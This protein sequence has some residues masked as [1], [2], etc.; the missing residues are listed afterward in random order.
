LSLYG[1]TNQILS[2]SSS[3]KVLT[4]T[5]KKLIDAKQYQEALNVFDQQSEM[6]TDFHFNMALKAC[7][8]LHNYQYGKKIHQQ[9]S[10]NSLNN[11]FIQSSLINF[12]SESFIFQLENC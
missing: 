5:M 4:S 9:L 11:P 2:I 1:K 10:S 7:A 3:S 6:S 8:H 12:Y